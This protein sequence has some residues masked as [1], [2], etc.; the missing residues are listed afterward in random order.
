MGGKYCKKHFLTF[1]CSVTCPLKSV[2]DPIRCSSM[3]FFIPT[4]ITQITI[5]TN[6]AFAFL[7]NTRQTQKKEAP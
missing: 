3:S 5:I 7:F 1:V 4:A 2:H 6:E